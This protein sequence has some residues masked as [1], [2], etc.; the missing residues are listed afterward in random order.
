MTEVE[1]DC[2]VLPCDMPVAHTD[3][4]PEGMPMPETRK[5]DGPEAAAARPEDAWTTLDKAAGESGV[6][7][8]ALLKAAA[9]GD[10]EVEERGGITSVT[11]ASVARYQRRA[12]SEVTPVSA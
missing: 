8:Y 2:I 9:R 3:S 11:R 5:E 1:R 10:L 6:S 7:R 4:E 12:A